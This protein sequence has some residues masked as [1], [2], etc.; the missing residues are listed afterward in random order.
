M[1]NDNMTTSNDIIRFNIYEEQV[2][3]KSNNNAQ[4]TDWANEKKN[5]FG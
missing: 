3:E 1:G 5:C 2:N 4:K